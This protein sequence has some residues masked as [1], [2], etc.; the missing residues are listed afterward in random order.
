[1]T[2]RK[3]SLLLCFGILT[4][5]TWVRAELWK[6]DNGVYRSSA[7]EGANCQQV[8]VG[9]D[10]KGGKRIIGA[11]VSDQTEVCQMAKERHEKVS[12]LRAS[13][14]P[15]S[16]SL[17]SSSN[18]ITTVSSVNGGSFAGRAG[19]HP[20]YDAVMN[21]SLSI[22]KVDWGSAAREVEAGRDPFP[23]FVMPK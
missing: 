2:L 16:Q 3:L 12:K 22:H 5:S 4:H 11:R 1:M 19:A 20:A 9:I 17:P 10:C 7:L 15:S 18:Q 8:K 6:C 23:N 14:I 13:Y 21:D